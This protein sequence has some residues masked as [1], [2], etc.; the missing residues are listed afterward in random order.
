MP[1]DYGEFDGRLYVLSYRRPDG[2][3]ATFEAVGSKKVATWSVRS[4]FRESEITVMTVRHC[5]H[6]TLRLENAPLGTN[7]HDHV[8]GYT[9]RIDVV[10]HLPTYEKI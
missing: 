3:V 2:T 6:V 4:A 5:H 10:G 9:F 8:T 7:I 1:V